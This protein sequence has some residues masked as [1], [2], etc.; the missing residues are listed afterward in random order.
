MNYHILPIAGLIKIMAGYIVQCS[1]KA[2]SERN[3]FLVALSGGSMPELLFPALTSE[4]VCSEI[5]WKAWHVF[6]AD[7]RCVPPG[8]PESNYYLACKHLFNHVDI[9]SSRIYTPNT[10]VAPAEMAALYQLKLQEVFHIKGEE[11]PRFDL[12]LLGMGED[13]HTASLFPN[14]PLLKEKKRWVAPVFDAPK[15]PP[16]RITLTLPVI[17][18]A[19]CIIFLITGKNKAAAVKKIIQAESAP[20]PLPAQ[21]VK[22]V[23]GELHWFLDENAASELSR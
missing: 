10:S 18:N 1:K 6:W 14:H 16:E 20:A 13:G 21:M 8:N 3:R 4:P 11:L 2:I 17:N 15:P 22:P 5:D 7:E 23:H 19:H 12:L 9:P